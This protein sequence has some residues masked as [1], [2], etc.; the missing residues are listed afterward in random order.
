MGCWRFNYWNLDVYGTA[1]L[2][3]PCGLL[4]PEG[5][6]LLVLHTCLRRKKNNVQQR[7][8]EG[9][10]SRTRWSDV[11]HHIRC[12][13][14]IRN[15]APRRDSASILAALVHIYDAYHQNSQTRWVL[16]SEN[17]TVAWLCTETPESDVSSVTV[18]EH[19]EGW[20]R[21]VMV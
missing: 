18:T 9:S 19:G 6:N 3:L 8:C 17:A 16:L 15:N 4:L 5:S 12:H 14:L 1:L 2:L 20:V 7:G 11:D 13:T 10:P 21:G